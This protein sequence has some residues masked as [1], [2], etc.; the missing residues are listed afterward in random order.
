V[1]FATEKKLSQS[2]APPISQSAGSPAILIQP[3]MTQSEV[4]LG[5]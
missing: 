1:L 3:I 5:Q 4:I 2:L